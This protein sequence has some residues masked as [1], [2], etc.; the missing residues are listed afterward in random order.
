MTALRLRA[1]TFLV[2][3][4]SGGLSATAQ[5]SN[6][7]DNGDFYD[8][9][10]VWVDNTGLGSDDLHSAGATMIPGWSVVPGF[11]NEFWAAASN[12]YNLTASPGNGSGFWVDLTGQ[13]NDKPYGGIQQAIATTAG[14]TYT[15]TFD[16]GAS[17]QYNGPDQGAAALTA[18]AT[19]SAELASVEFT[20]SPTTTNQWASETLSF[21]ADSSST[22]ISFLADSTFTSEYTGLDNVNV[23]ATTSAVPEPVPAMTLMAGL[24]LIASV[25]RRRRG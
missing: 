4:A 16:L 18:S 22:E 7:V 1:L 3:A 10:S 15:L 23:V 6:L 2:A 8:V 20:L 21:T 9:T 17:T 5:A 13:A 19:G 14:T 12:S 25:L 11:G 24:A